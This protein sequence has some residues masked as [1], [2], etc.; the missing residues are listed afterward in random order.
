MS[1]SRRTFL[2]GGRSLGPLLE[3]RELGLCCVPDLKRVLV[4]ADQLLEMRRHRAAIDLGV[5]AGLADALGDVEDDAREALSVDP[6]LL[7]VR[8]LPQLAM[9]MSACFVSLIRPQAFQGHATAQLWWL[10]LRQTYL[11]SAKCS[12]RSQTIAPPKRGV[13]TNSGISSV[14][15]RSVGGE[16]GRL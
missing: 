10:G 11:T 1:V 5:R 9:G 12:G 3:P 16:C 13:D 8:Y 7:V 15:N 14:I 4:G 6:D 2:R